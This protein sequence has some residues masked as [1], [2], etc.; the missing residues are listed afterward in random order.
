MNL[1]VHIHPLSF[2]LPDVIAMAFVF[3]ALINAPWR[4][5]MLVGTRMQLF[6]ATIVM[7]AV[8]WSFL[9]VNVYDIYQIHPLLISGVTLI[10]GIQLALVIGAAAS[11]FMHVLT[12]MP[13]ENIGFHYCVNVIVATLVCYL[14]LALIQKVRIQNLFVY[15]LGGS[16]LG[17]M[18][19]VVVTGGVAVLFLWVSGSTLL[20]TALDHSYLFLMLTFPEGFINGAIITML[21]VLRPEW[22]KTYDDGFYLKR[23]EG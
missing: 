2:W 16:F 11:I 20:W 6:F 12:S 1:L 13:W 21:V 17:S 14:V 8:V 5:L 10:F 4:S 19:A 7:L 9:V 15:L 18:L 3:W 22:V 23:P